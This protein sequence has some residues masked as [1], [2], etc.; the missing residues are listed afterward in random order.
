MGMRSEKSGIEFYFRSIGGRCYA[1]DG[2][3]VTKKP[4]GDEDEAEDE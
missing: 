2:D 1:D 4:Q 3:D